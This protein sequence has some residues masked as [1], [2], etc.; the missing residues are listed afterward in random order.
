MTENGLNKQ[1]STSGR[2]SVRTTI[3]IVIALIVFVIL[4]AVGGSLMTSAQDRATA[5]QTH[6]HGAD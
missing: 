5:E 1:H 3:I 4:H 2:M 6:L